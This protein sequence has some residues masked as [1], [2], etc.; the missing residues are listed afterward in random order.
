MFEDFPVKVKN[1]WSLTPPIENVFANWTQFFATCHELAEDCNQQTYWSRALAGER[2]KH[3]YWLRWFNTLITVLNSS[4]GVWTYSWNLPSSQTFLCFYIWELFFPCI[5]D[6]C[7]S[8]H[9]RIYCGNQD[10]PCI[11]C[12]LSICVAFLMFHKLQIFQVFKDIA[13]LLPLNFYS[14]LTEPC[15]TVFNT[16][17]VLTIAVKPS[18][19]APTVSITRCC[20]TFHIY[21][22]SPCANLCGQRTGSQL[23]G[24]KQG[25]SQLQ[26]VLD[27][28]SP[29]H[30]SHCI[31]LFGNKT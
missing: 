20:L 3:V 9:K 26:G 2:T 15:K 14:W 31:G 29:V 11:A 1:N 23:P 22:C 8:F 27:I 24:K 10:L 18:L 21:L 19:L 4:G 13:E 7:G 6:L 25:W 30:I 12:H 5:F 16:E 17:Q 28:I